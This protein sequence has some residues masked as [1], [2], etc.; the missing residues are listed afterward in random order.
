[1][2]REEKEAHDEAV[3]KY[4]AQQQYEGEEVRKALEKQLIS[5]REILPQHYTSA[6]E[7]IHALPF[8]QLIVNKNF[9]DF[10]LATFKKFAPLFSSIY[11]TDSYDNVNGHFNHESL[12]AIY[13]KNKHKAAFQLV[14]GLN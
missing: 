9:L 2:N 6:S 4:R 11:S 14:W 12:D 13:E 7:Y 5:E 10:F 3:K 8:Y 1:M